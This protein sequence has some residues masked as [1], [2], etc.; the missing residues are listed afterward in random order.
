MPKGKLYSKVS[1]VICKMRD[2][3]GV[4]RR[5]LADVDGRDDSAS[6]ELLDDGSVYLSLIHI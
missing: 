4:C 3:G 1:N 5:V 2:L 6:W